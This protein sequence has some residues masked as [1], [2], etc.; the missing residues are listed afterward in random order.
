MTSWARRLAPIAMVL[1]L[2]GCSTQDLPLLGHPAASMDGHTISMSDYDARLNLYKV[3]RLRQ[4]AQGGARL[5]DLESAAGHSDKLR[6][7]DKAVGDLVEE[8]ILHDEAERRKLAVTEADVTLQVDRA[9]ALFK[10][11]AEFQKGLKD[12]G[13]DLSGLRQQLHAR[14]VEI[15]V[16]DSIAQ[17]RVY[18]ALKDLAGGKAFADV[19]RVWSDFSGDPEVSLTP[20]QQAKL[21]PAA[22]PAI[23]ALQPGDT[24]KVP[25]RGVNGYFIFHLVSR[26][27]A[28]T[29]LQLLYVSAPDAAHYRAGMRPKWF[30]TFLSGMVKKVHVKYYVGSR[31]A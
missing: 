23:T 5:P 2:A 24:S 21:D 6:L 20:E 7:E 30:V 18:T 9:R 14:L 27:T 4:D 25:V 28:T 12:Y 17:D 3:L 19:A 10:S 15:R 16:V 31:A 26:D 8:A 11:D 22:V 29:R 13:Y 1:A